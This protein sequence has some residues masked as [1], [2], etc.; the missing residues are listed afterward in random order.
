MGRMSLGGVADLFTT[1]PQKSPVSSLSTPASNVGTPD[2][3][4]YA[5]I[6]DTPNGPGE[7]FVSPMSENKKSAR[8]SVN[9]VGVKELFKG[10]TTSKS[11]ATPSGVARLFS[12][13]VSK[14]KVFFF[15]FQ[16]WY[17]LNCIVPLT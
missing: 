4:L 10:K 6:P 3:V 1:P 15:Q 14:P 13:P 5:D 16:H 11:P 17:N 8:K 12:T 7:M 2:S 9:L